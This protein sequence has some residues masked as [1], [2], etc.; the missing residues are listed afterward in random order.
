MYAPP[1]KM[2]ILGHTFVM[3][4]SLFEWLCIGGGAIIFFVYFFKYI[5]TEILLTDKRILYK[6]GL[7]AV[8]AE[9]LELQEVKE[10][11]VNH[12][13]FGYLLNYGAIHLDCRFVKDL[14]LPVVG[15]PIRL[16]KAIY[17][18]RALLHA[19]DVL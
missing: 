15:H 5:S 3:S 8:K 1:D 6:T 13:L 19:P 11:K 12:G 2:H 14:D 16:M 9:E 18:E 4:V 17:K 10:E 7:V